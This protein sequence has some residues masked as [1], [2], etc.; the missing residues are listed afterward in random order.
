MLTV[1]VVDGDDL[2]AAYPVAGAALGGA[3][4]CVVVARVAG[5]AVPGALV[6]VS[7]I[8]AVSP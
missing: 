2:T 1:L 7:A 6:E 5:I 4:P 3:A 8:A